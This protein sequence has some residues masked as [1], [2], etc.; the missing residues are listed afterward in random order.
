MSDDRPVTFKDVFAVSEY[1]AVWFA[2][3]ASWIGDYLA[4]AAVVVLVFRQ[5]ESISL[6]AAAFAVSYLPWLLFGTVLSALA[7]RH[8]YRGVMVFCDLARMAVVALLVVPGVPWPMVLAVMFLVTLGGVPIQ[9]ARSALMPLMLDRGRLA[10]AM[11]ANATSVQAAQVAGYLTGATLAAAANPQLAIAIVAVLFGTSALLV[12]A[13]VL[14]RPPAVPAEQRTHLLRET[15]AGF[16]LVFGSRVLR[17]IALMVFAMAAFAIVPEGLAAGWAAH[18]GHDSVTRGIDQGLIMAAGPVGFVIGG[19]AVGRLVSQ[20][21]RHRLIR[22]FAVLAPL[23]LVPALAAPPVP[24][25]VLLTM[26]SGVAQG[27]LMPTLNT[28]FVLTLPHGYRA[29]AFGVMQQGLQVFQGGAVLVTGV[30]AER[31]SVPL[32]VGVWSVAGVLS[33]LLLAGRWPRVRTPEPVPGEAVLLPAAEPS[34][35]AENPPPGAV[36]EP[37]PGRHRFRE[38][39]GRMDG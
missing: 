39:A 31:W 37:T 30:L 15:A 2:L 9:A 25:V 16:R 18:S 35:R 33:M 1:R 38:A 29:R 8:A 17:S 27:G 19:L 3:V 14:P 5:T 13:Y 34:A 21:T 7:E 4:R 23:A 32:V 20:E 22:P 28:H 24:V 26:L 36:T 11:A 10:V 12:R 6:S